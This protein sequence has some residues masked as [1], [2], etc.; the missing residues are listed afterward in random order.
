LFSGNDASDSGSSVI[1][2]DSDGHDDG[3]AEGTTRVDLIFGGLMANGPG[4]EDTDPGSADDTLN[5]YGGDDTIYGGIGE[6]TISGGDEGDQIETE[7]C[8]Y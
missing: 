6:D 4:D 5:G 7:I 3:Y 1:Y 2:D 8:K